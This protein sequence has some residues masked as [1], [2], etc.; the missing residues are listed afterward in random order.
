MGQAEPVMSW[1]GKLW[2][3][4]EGSKGHQIVTMCG[5]EVWCRRGKVDA[6]RKRKFNKG[7]RKRKQQQGKMKRNGE[8]IE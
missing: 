5:R 1:G 4:W 2:G 7:E 6:I 3:G 8:T